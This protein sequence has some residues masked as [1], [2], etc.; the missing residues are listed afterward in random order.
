MVALNSPGQMETE[1]RGTPHLRDCQVT[2]LE[3]QSIP[4]GPGSEIRLEPEQNLI[5]M[6]T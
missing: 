4:A 1:D 6:G 5:Q 2:N 3:S